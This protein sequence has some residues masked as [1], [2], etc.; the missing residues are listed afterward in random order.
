MPAFDFALGHRMIGR[1]AQVLDVAVIEPFGEVAGDVAG[2]VV[3]QKPWSIGWL[4]LIKATGPQRQ[5]KGWR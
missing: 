2:T 1:A 3:G 5:I 4:G